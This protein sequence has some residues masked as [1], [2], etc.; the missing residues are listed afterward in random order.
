MAAV[1]LAAP[2][3]AVTI[4]FSKT[5]PNFGIGPTTPIFENFDSIGKGYAPVASGQSVALQSPTGGP[6]N[7]PNARVFSSN[8]AGQ[9]LRPGDATAPANALPGLSSGNYG[10]VGANGRYTI[11]FADYGMPVLRSFSYSHGS[12]SSQN[13]ITLISETGIAANNFVRQ[14][15]AI[16]NN[17]TSTVGDNYRVRF[18]A[19]SAPGAGWTGAIFE[20]TSN[21]FEFDNFAG[22]APEPQAWAMLTL[23]FGLTGFALRRSRK[24]VTA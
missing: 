15:F 10:A 17:D 16:V 20:G 5:N 2:S 18:D 19:G 3:Q 13:K 24:S 12:I 8:V 21:A 22:A 6:A 7:I 23:G 11:I 14:G 1:A 4:S 9:A